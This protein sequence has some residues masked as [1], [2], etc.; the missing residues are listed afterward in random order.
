MANDLLNR[1]RSDG[2]Q[3]HQEYVAGRLVWICRGIIFVTLEKLEELLYG[4]K[5]FIGS[6]RA[7]GVP[8]AGEEGGQQPEETRGGA[9]IGLF[10]DVRK[11]SGRRALVEREPGSVKG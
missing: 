10:A 1:L 11:K 3:V 7:G 2:V 9:E 4:K 8:A 5:V 6:V